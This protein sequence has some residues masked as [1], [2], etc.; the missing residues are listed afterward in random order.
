MP[1]YVYKHACIQVC[2]YIKSISWTTI[3]YY[4]NDL[5][6]VRSMV[7]Y[8][9]FIIKEVFWFIYIYIAREEKNT[10]SNFFIYL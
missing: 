2:L 9:D 3:Y 5:I 10:N 6:I 4:C 8:M 7:A 1:V